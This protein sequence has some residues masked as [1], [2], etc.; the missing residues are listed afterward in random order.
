ML[1]RRQW[2]GSGIV[3]VAALGVA[4]LAVDSIENDRD[5]LAAIVPVFLAGTLPVDAAARQAE[6]A[7]TLDGFDIAVSGLTPSVQGEVAQLLAL[8][9]VAPLRIVA[10]GIV[11]P[12][13]RTSPERI[14]QFLNDWRFNAIPKLRSAYQALHQLIFAAYY[15]DP[16]AWGRIHYPGPPVVKL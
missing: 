2:I 15:G 8:L 3:A 5:I 12:W 11:G 6:I 1:T 4:G 9:R 13:G 10:T 16:K 14:A 7:R